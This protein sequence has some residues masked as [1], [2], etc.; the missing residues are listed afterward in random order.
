MAEKLSGIDEL[1]DAVRAFDG[2]SEDFVQRFS[3]KGLLDI[4]RAWRESEWDFSPDK[5]E[6]RQVKEA[7]RRIV[8]NWTADERPD[9]SS[10][11]P[12]MVA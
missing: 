5:W 2:C 1:R 10:T 4:R 8:P 9:Y 6:A 11:N 7:L 3:T 12:K